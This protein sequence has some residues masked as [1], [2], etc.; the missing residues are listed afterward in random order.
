MS[1]D[2]IISAKNHV[3]ALLKT[4]RA[5][6]HT[7]IATRSSDPLLPI[8]DGKCVRVTAEIVDAGRDVNH[9]LITLAGGMEY[10]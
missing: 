10:V 6:R 1:D 2:L 3:A 5:L 7:Y 4:K 9:K 8:P